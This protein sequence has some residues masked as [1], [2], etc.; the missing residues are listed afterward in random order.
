MK[1][2]QKFFLILLFLITILFLLCSSILKYSKKKINITQEKIFTIPIG[3]G[4]I[5][6]ESL[7]IKEKI[8][9]KNY[10]FQLLFKICHKLSKLKAGTYKFQPNM[11]IKDILLLISKGDEAQFSVCFI[12]G[13]RLIELINVLDNTPYLKHELQKMTQLEIFSKIG[14]KE[15]SK[16]EGWIYPDTYFYTANTIDIS[17]LKR[18]YHRMKIILNKEWQNRDKFL[19]YKTAYEML[20][21]ASIIE[22]ESKIN[23]E[24]TQISSVFINRLRN[25][26]RLQTDPTVIYGIGDKYDGKIYKN[27]L[28]NYTEYNTYKIHG[29]PPTPISMPSI[30]SIKAAAH[31][32]KTEY[33][34]FVANNKGGHTF[35]K[36][37]NDH[38]HLVKHLR[39]IK[40][41]T[42]KA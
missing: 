6:L 9:N 11:T 16:L 24:K 25:K 40:N 2:K 13:S 23:N 20:I 37:L 28:N 19:P 4:R 3:I 26:M 35:S 8:I 22:K 42:K 21:L 18:A 31:P 27:D 15:S 34:Y 41:K 1:L 36:N 10:K 17:I 32:A 14:F 5:T 29:L 30:S 12:E 7:L 38:N 39:D 33:L